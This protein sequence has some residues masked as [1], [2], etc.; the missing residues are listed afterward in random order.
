MRRRGRR[1]RS[2]GRQR[3]Q[4]AGRTLRVE[5]RFA[6]RFRRTRLHRM[7]PH[8]RCHGPLVSRRRSAACR[9][10]AHVRPAPARPAAHPVPLPLPGGSR[11]R[12]CRL[13]PQPVRCPC[14]A[15]AATPPPVCHHCPGCAPPACRFRARSSPCGL[16]ARRPVCH[17]PPA[18]HRPRL[19]GAPAT[20]APQPRGPRPQVPSA[21]LSD[22]PAGRPEKELWVRPPHA[23]SPAAGAASAPAACRPGS[24]ARPSAARP[25]HP[26][27]GARGPCRGRACS[28]RLG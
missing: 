28:S 24:A 2:S 4:A 17:Q 11:R 27:G 9:L 5:P 15:A 6:A 10:Y 21:G 26:G 25:S 23:C 8:R 1:R 14:P 18:H 16:E 3:Q 13:P 19:G 12:A 7:M 22:Q 20:A